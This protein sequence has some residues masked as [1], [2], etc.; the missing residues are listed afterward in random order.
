VWC[1]RPEAAGSATAE[2][3]C[4]VILRNHAVIGELAVDDITVT[5]LP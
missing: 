3:Q 4:V 1:G 5:R 2:T